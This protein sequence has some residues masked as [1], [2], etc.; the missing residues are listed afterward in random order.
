[1]TIHQKQFI[2]NYCNPD[3]PTFGNGTQSYLK[4]YP[5]ASYATAMREAYRNLRKPHILKEIEC[6]SLV[7]GLDME[8][9]FRALC[10]I[11]NSP[12][13][14]YTEITYD[15]ETGQKTKRSGP[16]YSEII[17]VIDMINKACGLY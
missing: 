7:F 10:E 6:L 5:N 16:K 14:G 12:D 1:M 15:A 2:I 17:K 11:L 9:R 3:S 13:I 4:A 8:V